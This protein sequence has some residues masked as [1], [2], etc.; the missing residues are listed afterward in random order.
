M[1]L[2]TAGASLR[3]TP[4][5]ASLPELY[6][7]AA[8]GEISEVELERLDAE[9]RQPVAPRLAPSP[10][11]LRQRL[12]GRFRKPPRQRSPDYRKSVERRRRLAATWPAPPAMLGRLTPC[13]SALCRILVDEHHKQGRCEASHDEL[14]ARVGCSRE[15][16]KRGLRTLK[17]FGWITVTHR[18]VKGQKHRTNIVRIIAPQWLLWVQHGPQP[19]SGRPPLP[20]PVGEHFRPATVNQLN[21][22]PVDNVPWKRRRAPGDDRGVSG[23]RDGL[24]D[25]GGM[26]APPT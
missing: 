3:G 23:D 26:R 16:V 25:T 8:R 7:A 1:S 20:T 17:R 14:A 9:L 4:L 18:P 15:T 22:T 6:A 19:R 13:E 12:P 24:P 2:I 11:P 5:F 21:L 10:R